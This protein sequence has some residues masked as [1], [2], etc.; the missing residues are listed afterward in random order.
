MRE[1]AKRERI[2]RAN[3]PIIEE[4]PRR[5]LA[6]NDRREIGCESRARQLSYIVW[7]N[8]ALGL[9]KLLVGRIPGEVSGRKRTSPV[10]KGYGPTYDS[11]DSPS[12][13]FRS[14]T[15]PSLLIELL[16]VLCCSTLARLAGRHTLRDGCRI[17]F[18]HAV[19]ARPHIMFAK[20]LIAVVLRES[21]RGEHR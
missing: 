14:L 6:A 9:L 19:R 21:A 4:R 8:E 15:W 12:G 10:F 5:G 2:F 3:W 13:L 20:R 17:G 16:R 7:S 18:I 1:A 11:C